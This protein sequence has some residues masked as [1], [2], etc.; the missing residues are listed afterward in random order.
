M[1]EVENQNKSFSD[2]SSD[3]DSPPR[4][5]KQKSSTLRGRGLAGLMKE[6]QPHSDS[7]EEEEEDNEPSQFNIYSSKVERCL[8]NVKTKNYLLDISLVDEDVEEPLEEVPVLCNSADLSEDVIEVCKQ[9]P[10]FDDSLASTSTEDISSLD[11]FSPLPS[12]G[13][14]RHTKQ[15]QSALNILNRA[16]DLVSIDGLN[17]SL[18]LDQDGSQEI[19][20]T[21]ASPVIEKEDILVKVVH[22]GKAH[23]INIKKLTDIIDCHINENTSENVSD[24]QNLQTDYNVRNA[25]VL[26]V[27]SQVRNSKVDITVDKTEP[28]RNLLEKYAAEKQLDISKLVF[29]FDGDDVNP[30]DTPEDLDMDDNDCIDV[31]D[32]KSEGVKATAKNADIVI[33]DDTPQKSKSKKRNLRRSRRTMRQQPA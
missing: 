15:L 29:K 10:D 6:C 27:Q 7:E 26:C 9:R 18:I 8:G 13:A 30:N 1:A 2:S 20:I 32:K 16:K 33:I 19:L 14:P 5:K 21:G 25:I 4:I 24:G 31:I 12:V 11:E 23:R 28:I 17:T 3:E 22:K